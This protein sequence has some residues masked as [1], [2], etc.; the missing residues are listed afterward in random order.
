[1]AL[2]QRLSDAEQTWKGFSQEKPER[3]LQSG[4]LL[5]KNPDGFLLR[6]GSRGV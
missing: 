6:H 5:N 2:V 3:K 4:F 1:M